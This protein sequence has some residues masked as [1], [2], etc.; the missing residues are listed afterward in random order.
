VNDENASP[1]L[2][3]KLISILI[4]TIVFDRREAEHPPYQAAEGHRHA[5]NA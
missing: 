2:L 3:Q 1:E 5:V 4:I